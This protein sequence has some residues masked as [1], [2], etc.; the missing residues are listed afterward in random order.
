P[1]FALNDQNA[2]VAAQ[3]CARLDGI[4]LA[5]ELA[6]A[7]IKV[8]PIGQILSRLE[9]R[10]RLLTAGSPGALPH[11][12]TL[13][14]TVDSSY[15]LLNDSER[16]LF[17][18]ARVVAGGASVEALERVTAGEGFAEEDVLDLVTHLVD[19]SL[20]TPEEGV[21][22]AA[23]YRLLETLREYGRSKLAGA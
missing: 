1:T 18:R 11:Q 8:L 17:Q 3:I 10:F 23:R 22:G 6:A 21:G 4:P 16:A 20:L 14:A 7:R 2:A 19:K 12:Q 13:R 9:D 5:I 15:D